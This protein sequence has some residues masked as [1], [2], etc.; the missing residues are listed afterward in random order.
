VNVHPLAELIPPMTDS[1]FSEL[2]ADIEANGLRQTITLYE[3]KILDGRHRARACDEL[4]LEPEF[5][6][7]EG[8]DPAGYVISLNLS[9]RHL[10]TGQRS[11]AAVDLRAWERERP[12]G[13]RDRQGTRTDLTSV[14]NGTKVDANE[15]RASAEAGKK[16]GVS[17]SSVERAR[18]V[19][20]KRPDLAEKVKA[21]EM[22]VNTAFDEARGKEKPPPKPLDV[23]S[24]HNKNVANKAKERVQSLV[25]RLEGY[26]AGAS[27][28][29]LDHAFAVADA[30]DL[31]HWWRSLSESRTNLLQLQKAIK[32]EVENRGKA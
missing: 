18:T 9:R 16:F 14:P 6:D 24:T 20:E 10:T 31:N 28:I 8:D 3:D 13:T 12:G 32:Q 25:S 19:A 17:R 27:N 5:M 22:T 2:K 11:M 7:Y 29:R 4:G 15:S 23:S 30:D 21:G 26:A 1:E